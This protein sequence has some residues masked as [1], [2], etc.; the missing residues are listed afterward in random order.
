MT[1]R[2]PQS[3]SGCDLGI[4]CDQLILVVF[5]VEVEWVT[6]IEID[7]DHVGV[8]HGEFAEAKLVSAVCH[9]IACASGSRRA[10]AKDLNYPVTLNMDL[11][12]MALNVRRRKNLLRVED[13]VI[14][15]G[16]NACNFLRIDE[17]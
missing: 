5:E 11:I 2:D 14:A 1:H 15:V 16:T 8:S 13:E 6:R 9:V 4:P 10:R 12:H 3:E 17:V 7:Q